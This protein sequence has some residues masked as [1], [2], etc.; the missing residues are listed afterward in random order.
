MIGPKTRFT[1]AAASDRP[2]EICSACSTRRLVM[3]STNWPKE[4]S[5]VLRNSAAS[6][7]S[8]IRESQSRL[9]PSVTPKPGITLRLRVVTAAPLICVPLLRIDLVEHT[10]IVKVR[11]LRLLPAAE[12]IVDG[13]QLDFGEIAFV[14]P[15]DR[16]IARPI[17]VLRGDFLAF[18]R[19]DEVEISLRRRARALLVDHLVNNRDCRLGEDRERRHHDLELVLAEFVDRQVRFVLPGNQHIADV[20]LDE[21]HR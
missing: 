1:V 12:H 14:L 18:G 13:E 21:C 19:V 17:M 16:R 20:A 9:T 10:G 3:M 2:K 6:G 11:R 4:S 8:T 15:G 5:A 7:T